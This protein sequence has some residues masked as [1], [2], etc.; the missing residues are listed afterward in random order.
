M[1]EAEVEF[2]SRRNAKDHWRE[3]IDLN[4]KF[5]PGSLT[6]FHKKRFAMAILIC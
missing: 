1:A 5:M 2:C 3:K 4:E 6:D